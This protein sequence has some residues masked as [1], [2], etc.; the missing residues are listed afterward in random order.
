MGFL[1]GALLGAPA[2]TQVQPTSP[3]G[4]LH[5]ADDPGDSL[6][7]A[8]NDGPQHAGRQVDQACLFEQ[9]LSKTGKPRFPERPNY[10]AI[11]DALRNCA[12]L[13]AFHR[14]Q[15]AE[16]F[17]IFAKIVSLKLTHSGGLF[18]ASQLYY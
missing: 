16:V 12:E 14:K 8:D 2:V 4:L 18:R 5:L 11:P 6:A 10:R 15:G 3:L 17:F 7:F 9:S 13:V 1:A